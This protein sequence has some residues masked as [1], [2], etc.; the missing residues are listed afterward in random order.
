MRQNNG[1]NYFARHLNR[2]VYNIALIA[3]FGAL[4]F[5]FTAFVA[6]PVGMG[7]VNLGDIFIFTACM[8]LGYFA[9]IPAAVGSALADIFLGYTFY[10]PATLIIKGLMAVIFLLIKGKNQS[11]IRI[12]IGM[13]TGSVFMQIGYTAYEVILAVLGNPHA[14]AISAILAPLLILSNFSQTLFGVAGGW[15][16]IKVAQKLNLFDRM[17]IIAS[18]EKEK[19]E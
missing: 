10:A 9:L 3:V 5:V 12:L 18:I 17:K 1:S 8:F 16:L 11:N 4:I 15:V 6:F 13:I 7:Y 19:H 14:S 2:S